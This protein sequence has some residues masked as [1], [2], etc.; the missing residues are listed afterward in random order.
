MITRR[1]QAIPV[2]PREQVEMRDTVRDADETGITVAS[3]ERFSTYTSEKDG[4][5]ANFRVILQTKKLSK[6]G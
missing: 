4:K 6:G 2:T 5:Y 3:L 1:K